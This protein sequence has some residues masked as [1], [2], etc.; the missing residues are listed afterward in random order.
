MTAAK[1]NQHN[2]EYCGLL[3]GGAESQ[4]WPHQS[5]EIRF[6]DSGCFPMRLL[7]GPEGSAKV[8]AAILS[9]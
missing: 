5:N 8:L 9:L 4:A 7:R 2:L 3:E 6:R 1:G